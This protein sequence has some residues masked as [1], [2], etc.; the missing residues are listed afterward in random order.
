MS[1]PNTNSLDAL[2]D[3]IAT[4]LRTYKANFLTQLHLALDRLTPQQII[5]IVIIA[6][7]YDAVIAPIVFPLVKRAARREDAPANWRIR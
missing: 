6:A 4:H 3:N 2:L 7:I 5:R 1:A